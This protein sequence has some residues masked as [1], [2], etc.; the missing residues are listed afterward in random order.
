[1]A[2]NPAFI[3]FSVLISCLLASAQSGYIFTAPKVI[4]SHRPALFRLT[5][6]DVDVDGKVSVRL[7]TYNNE[8]VVLA[9][10]EYDVKQGQL[11][12]TFSFDVPEYSGNSAKIEVNGTFGDYVFSGKKEID[13]QKSKD[14]VLIQTDKALY[15]PGQKVQLRVLPIT[16]DLTPVTSAV[17]EIYITSP[18]EARIAQ[19][20]NVT[21]ER[22]IA[23]FDFKLT[24]EPEFGLWQ[25][26]AEFP[27][28]TVRQHFEVNEYVLPKFEVTVTPPSYLLANAK[29]VVWKI[30][31]TYTFGQPVEGTLLANVT[32]EKYHW[33]TESF[34]YIE[35]Q[36]PI[37]GCFDFVVNTTALRFN[38][39]YQVYKR[40]QLFAQVNETGTGI[41]L[42]K[43]SY[44][45]RTSNPLELKFVAEE[46]GNNYFKPLMPY[47]GTLLV[48]KPD[49]LPLP[50]ELI[51]LCLLTQSEIIKTLWWRT[52]RRLSCKN[53]TSDHFGLVKFTLPPL[54]T[55][56]VT[57][58]VEAT[59]V[60]YEAEKYDTYGTRINQPK[61]TLY[62]QAWYS[63]SNNF[64]Q[65]QPSKDPLPCTSDYKV[66]LRYTAEPDKEYLFHYQVVSRGQILKDGTVAAKFTQSES[67]PALV[68][69]TYLQEEVRNESLPS[70]VAENVSNVGS[71]ELDLTPDFS[72]VP[73]AK[74]LVFYIR[75]DGEV[76]ADSQEFEVEKCLKNNVTLRFGSE[77]VQ[78]ATTAAIH[79]SGS[80][81]SFCGV[82][83]VD[84]SVH[85]LKQD[86]QLTKAKV[87][88]LLK[89]LDISR[90]TWPRQSSY[91]YC[92]KKSS[93]ANPRY[94]RRVIWPGPRTSNVEYVDSITAF[95]E[96]GVIV[97][98]DLTLETRPCREAIYDRPP[99]ALAAPARGGGWRGPALEDEASVYPMAFAE[100]FDSVGAPGLPSP[101]PVPAKSA[102]EVRTYFPETWLW[103]LKE[104]DE[105]G[106]FD[107]KEK[108]P[109]TVTEWVGSAVCINNQDGIGVSDPAR[110]K[111]FQPFFASF[112]LPYSVIR[113][114][115][116]PVTLSVFNYLDKCLPVELTLAESEDFEFLDER[117]ATLCVCGS[118]TV[119][120]FLV[121]PK[122]IGEVNVTVSAVGSEN[123]EVCGEN[124]VEK[125][126]ARDAVT[127]QLLVEAEGFKKEE[128]KSV[129][130][131]SHGQGEENEKPEFELS[132]PEDVV[133]GSARAYIAVT[134]DIMGPAI[135]NLDSLVQVP[136]GCGEQNMVKF[137]PNVYVLDYLKATGKQD[138]DIEKKAVENLKT[139]YQRQQKYRHPDGSYSA[140]GTNDRQGSLF[141][142]A[143]VVR[144]F[145][146]AERYIPVYEKMLLESIS[147]IL[148][149]QLPANG[150]FDNVGR[151]LSSGLKGRVNESNPGPLTAYVLAALLEGGLAQNNVTEAA[152]QCIEAQRNPS[153]HNLALAAYVTALA[154]Q[155]VSAKLELLES[156]AD[157]EGGLTH[158]KNGGASADVETAAYAV[159]TYVKLGGQENLN[160]AQPIVRWMATQRNSR[161]GFSSTQD[162]VL[163]LQALSAFS[164]H[165]SK[166][167]VDVAVRV[168]GNEVNE[169]YDLKEESKLV[170]QQ[171]KVVDLPNTLTGETTGTGC[172][173][174]STTLKYNVHTPPKSQGFELTVTPLV[175]PTC[176]SALVKVCTKFDGEQPSNMAV[177]ELKLVSGYTTS[178]DDVREIYQKAD[179]ALKRHEI[180][181]NQVNF[182]F[183]EVTSEEKCFE[184]RVHRE[185]EVADAKPATVKVYDYYRLE[186]AKSVSYSLT[187][188]A[189]P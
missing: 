24:E 10:Q 5:L 48:K 7:L 165:L 39:N 62:L 68:D 143:F 15:K 61:N 133:E 20:K 138:A 46:H 100:S 13:F 102:V 82:G 80:P 94:A 9:Q 166:D 136:T 52:D 144:S 176:K 119:H 141:L 134:G 160:K 171:R 30:C 177:V 97:L 122:T 162:T 139:G 101:P 163:G 50:G 84:K 110:I 90:Y 60:N 36:G 124:P 86:N 31:A 96:I 64:I 169:A 152:L 132:L 179:V 42:N 182:Y 148:N 112:S 51:Q 99:Y 91:D 21:F 75:E 147:W 111:A 189:T 89:R 125:V 66:Q 37:N 108:I 149:K 173:L 23:Q 38:E 98:S 164:S 137:T 145:K 116:I 67:T 172:A 95:D 25:I 47:Y 71:L 114:E 117:S 16:N 107:F 156:I 106:S 140:F 88:D 63:A 150:C 120:K 58:S 43:T 127:R 81:L 11:E 27:T 49:G 72:Y 56:V 77:S 186:N 109:H 69:D 35:H 188:E 130:V 178:D 123:V 53:Y 93:G 3:S 142:T 184:V 2:W 28:Q 40:L 54:Q 78:P 154:G 115:V 74:L 104:L 174:I 57:V 79:L 126:V 73:L 70:N 146:Q 113:G 118:K 87:Y 175:D 22:G 59:A 12:N 18:S 26:V 6:T 14:H 55:T 185:I 135:K 151:V 83:V 121:K 17:A 158:W 103:D 85:L 29:E 45:T 76:I 181:K 128:T 168:S 1:M 34:P 33:E 92:R 8:S 159:L 187:C 105:H 180:D 129:F 41:T 19:W 4:R 32:Y 153:P 44:I 183:E 167:P 65:I 157:H 161:G 155:D 170:L 131:C